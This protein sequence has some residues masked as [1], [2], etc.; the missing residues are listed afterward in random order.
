MVESRLEN[1]GF[2]DLDLK[3][4]DITELEWENDYFDIVLDRGALTQNNYERINESVD[5][6]HRVLKKDT[7]IFLV[8]TLFGSNCS[9]KEFW[10]RTIKK[11]V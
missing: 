11:H 9:D 7:G 6:V 10:Q 2:K 4:G 1:L 5:E 8:Y 3:V